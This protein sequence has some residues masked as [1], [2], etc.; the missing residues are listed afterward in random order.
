MTYLQR[1]SISILTHRLKKNTRY[2][3]SKVL[4]ANQ[5]R[6]FHQERIDFLG[7]IFNKPALGPVLFQVI[8]VIHAQ[9]T[10]LTALIKSEIKRCRRQ[11]PEFISCGLRGLNKCC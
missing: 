7:N 2:L 11:Y 8:C 1:I 6:T 3:Y 10:A 9:T 4:T 5:R